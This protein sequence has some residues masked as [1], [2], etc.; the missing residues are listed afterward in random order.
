MKIG[1]LCP[2]GPLDR[3]GYQYNTLPILR[4][5]TTFGTK[6]YLCSSTRNR[7]QIDTILETFPTVEYIA[8]PETWFA[9][10]EHGDEVH[11]I[12]QITRNV[13]R[14]ME[15]AR[16]DGMDV[17]VSIHISQYVQD[18]AMDPLRAVAQRMLDDGRPYD[19]L[20]K[21]YQLYDRL[22]HADVRVPWIVN[23]RIDNPYTFSPDSLTQRDTGETVRIESADFRAHDD[24]A[25]VDCPM[26]RT[27][28]DLVDF[29]EFTRFYAELN[30]NAPT[31]FD[32]DYIR[33]YYVRKFN[34][35]HISD[36][37]LDPTGR[38]IAAASRPDFVSHLL[39]DR[40]QPPAPAPAAPLPPPAHPARRAVRRLRRL[41][42]QRIP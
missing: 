32:W 26:E 9:Q 1:I 27:P 4:S 25:I 29:K 8:G 11:E 22:F 36:E 38:A 16:R 20:H 2:I 15:H 40:Y 41:L 12:F 3:F 19:W 10:D 28:Q 13:T 33:E 30:P 6:V 21:K 5:L 23:L 35:K 17:G 34:V 18:R 24:V 37:P 31:G 42:R 39:L 7:A 14:M